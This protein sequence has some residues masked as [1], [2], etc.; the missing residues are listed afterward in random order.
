MIGGI[1]SYTVGG[2][3]DET[4][5]K[6]MRCSKIW[7]YGSK[8]SWH[9]GVSYTIGEIGGNFTEY[10]SGPREDFVLL[11]ESENFKYQVNTLT[12]V[13]TSTATFKLYLLS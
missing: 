13:I 11:Y 9:G 2:E 5:S 6:D 3:Q 8:C 12:F 7:V 10:T 4:A 1:R